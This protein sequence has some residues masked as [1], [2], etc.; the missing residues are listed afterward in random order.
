MGRELGVGVGTVLRL[1][2]EAALV[3]RLTGTCRLP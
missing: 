3:L 2:G 1:T